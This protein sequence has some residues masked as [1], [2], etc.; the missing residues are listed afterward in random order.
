[1]DCLLLGSSTAAA[2][3][4]EACGFRCLLPISP[5]LAGFS[6]QVTVPAAAHSSS[7]PAGSDA[8]RLFEAVRQGNSER[9]A[10]LLALGADPNTANAAG[11]RPLHIA[12]AQGNLEMIE[13]LLR[14]GGKLLPDAQGDGPEIYALKAGQ[15]EAVGKLLAANFER[16]GGSEAAAAEMEAMLDKHSAPAREL[17]DKM[18]KTYA[19]PDAQVGQLLK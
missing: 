14:S 6:M 18:N 17:R 5:K 12:A 8:E 16:I 11:Q 13:A 7:G 9:L 15:K 10:S 2:A 4:G 3:F 19:G 1:M